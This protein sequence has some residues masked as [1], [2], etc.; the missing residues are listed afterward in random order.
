MESDLVEESFIHGNLD[1][2]FS[3]REIKKINIE[4]FSNHISKIKDIEINNSLIWRMYKNLRTITCAHELEIVN[5]PHIFSKILEI[6]KE[7]F[8]I[9]EDKFNITDRFLNFNP[10]TPEDFYKITVYSLL[11]ELDTKIEAYTSNRRNDISLFFN[12]FFSNYLPFIRDKI[13]I[14][15]FISPYDDNSW[16]S[17]WKFIYEDNHIELYNIDAMIDT[18]FYNY[19][20]YFNHRMENDIKYL[21]ER[22]KYTKEKTKIYYSNYIRPQLLELSQKIFKNFPYQIIYKDYKNLLSCSENIYIPDSLKNIKDYKEIIDDEW[23]LGILPNYL[24]GY[25]L[26]YPIISCDIPSPKNMIDNIKKLI[27]DGPEKYYEYISTINKKRLELTS[28]GINC[29]NSIENNDILDLTLNRV[30]DYNMDDV[31]MIFNNGVCHYFTCQEF[32]ELLKKERNPYNRTKI[33]VF[34]LILENLRFKKKIK[35]EMSTR[36]MEVKLNNPMKENLEEIKKE[37]INVRDT[38]NNISDYTLDIFQN[39]IFNFLMNNYSTL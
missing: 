26:G 33:P 5:G 8:Q 18:Y 4:T 28:F 1:I 21:S 35:R 23:L 11:G 13:I 17:N 7:Y 29:G 16:T 12:N 39:P 32:E 2:C 19:N 14:C 3:L 31:I 38:D 15:D 24:S 37:I 34:N 22:I 9:V 25:I 27:K 10:V 20:V 6:I 36:G 30:I